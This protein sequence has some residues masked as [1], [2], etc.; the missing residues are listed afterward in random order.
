M[1]Q[2][3]LRACPTCGR[4]LRISAEYM[5]QIVI[6]PHCGG[7]FISGHR[8]NAYPCLPASESNLLR[9]ADALLRQAALK[10]AAS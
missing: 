4:P 1:D 10:L 3:K 5:D 2:T 9:R 6:C 8:G 7:K